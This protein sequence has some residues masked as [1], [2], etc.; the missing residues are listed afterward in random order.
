MLHTVHCT[1]L[2]GTQVKYLFMNTEGEDQNALLVISDRGTPLTQAND[3]ATFLTSWAL[4][5]FPGSAS[6]MRDTKSLLI[7]EALRLPPDCVLTK[8]DWLQ[9]SVLVISKYFLK[10]TTGHKI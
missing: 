7:V 4:G 8:T 5:S 2:V 10:L 9:L 1:V 3:E 6:S